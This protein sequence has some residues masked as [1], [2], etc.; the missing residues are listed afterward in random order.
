M[1]KAL[2]GW[3]L[4]DAVDLERAERLD[5]NWELGDFTA[6]L[7]AGRNSVW[8]YFGRDDLG[9]VAMRLGYSP[10]GVLSVTGF[11]KPE[12]SAS[13]LAMECELGTFVVTLQVVDETMSLV[14]ATTTL[15]PGEDLTVPFWPR[16][17][18]MCGPGPSPLKGEGRIRVT[19]SGP[20]SGLIF[21]SFD[22]SPTGSF[23]Y[24]QNLSRLNEY[25]SLTQT[26]GADTVG[27]QWPAVGF[28]LPPSEQ[29]IP[30]AR[31]TEVSDAFLTL[32]P[33][34]PEDELDA[35]ELFLDLLGGVYPEIP[36]PDTEYQDW[37]Q[38]VDR[39]LEDIQDPAAWTEVE[40]S[41]FIAAYLDDPKTPPES[42]VQLAVLVP[43]LEFGD[44]D[45]RA[46]GLGEQLWSQFAD[47]F[48]PAVGSVLRWH[49]KATHLLDDSE[50]HR[51]PRVMDSWYL[52]HPLI[53]LSRMAIHGDQTARKLLFDSLEYAI[54]VAH[55]FGYRWPVLFN[56]DTLD[57]IR[58]ETAEGEGGEYDVGGSYALLMMQ[59]Y[60]LTNDD[61]YLLEAKRA[62]DVMLERGFDIFYQLNDTCFGAG[63]FLR[64]W[65]HT[66][67][68]RYRRLSHLCLA[69]VFANAWLWECD[70]GHASA[71]PTFFSLFPLADAPYVAAY[72]EIEAVGALKDYLIR[73]GS[74]IRPALR[75]L[76]PEA[77]RYLLNKGIFYYPPRLP[78]GAVA[79]RPQV[80]T[81]KA[82]LWI[83]L[84]DLRD[85]WENF[86]QVGQ[87]V[88]G[89]GS[90]FG[91]VARHYHRVDGAILHNEYPL[92][93]LEH[94]PRRISLYLEGDERMACRIRLI[95][96]DR[97]L[98][99]ATLLFDGEKVAA[100]RQPQ[101]T[102]EGHL[103][104][105]VP[106]G[107][108][109]TLRLTPPRK[110]AKG[111]Q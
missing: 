76:I 77:L 42:M 30:G 26:S 34:V 97:P 78:A 14:R 66:G 24:F 3:A 70:Y 75:L 49:P 63:A 41:R 6:I 73:S 43:L 8:W 83:P 52:Y 69:S 16:D 95:P 53:N 35:G 84:E 56:V 104:W 106:A 61:R 96:D 51:Q 20:R 90:A 67:E 93:D 27:G 7:L 4:A 33:V 22:Q 111:K 9:G 108:R 50:E 102:P 45:D 99:D 72:E 80:G 110:P 39:S 62:A 18:L 71:Y 87:E 13:R 28:G 44:W 92:R 46:A 38:A 29:K 103:E 21:G 40:G 68:D 19:Q 11:E 94:S 15:T 82:H 60:D 107:R 31:S 36:R 5:A 58:A 12:K 88:Y 59:A 65:Q 55:Q 98:P 100:G 109:V 74:E 57:V 64:L 25:F 105:Q 81:I 32:T 23:L 47:F 48:D 10:A 91:I 89:A 54:T 17:L 86:G 37:L 101:R 1:H 85:G 2:S 79:D